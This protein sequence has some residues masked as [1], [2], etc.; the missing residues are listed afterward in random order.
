MVLGDQGTSSVSCIAD[1][2]LLKLS[3]LTRVLQRMQRD[4]LVE[5][6]RRASDNRVTEVSL[7]AKGLEMHTKVRSVASRVYQQAASDLTAKEILLL[8]DLLARMHD[9][10]AKSPYEQ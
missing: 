1:W 3:T 6:I 9:S 5:L 7:T 8:N 10:L 4:G 2:A